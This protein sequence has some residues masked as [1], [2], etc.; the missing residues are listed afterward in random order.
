LNEKIPELGMTLLQFR[1]TIFRAE[2]SEKSIGFNQFKKEL[3]S[4][5]NKK[6]IK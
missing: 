6:S 2:N 4:W 5:K 1:K 3:K